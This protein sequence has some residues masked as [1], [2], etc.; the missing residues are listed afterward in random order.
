M[1]VLVPQSLQVNIPSISLSEVMSKA[2]WDHEDFSAPLS[3][4]MV[5][6][7]Q[8]VQ[9]YMV[10]AGDN[11]SPC[12]WNGRQLTIEWIDDNGVPLFT[13]EEAIYVIN[14]TYKFFESVGRTAHPILRAV[15]VFQIANL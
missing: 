7:P 2:L 12:R 13:K 4:E 5:I 8:T 1:I 10:V 9:L 11:Q 6:P 3:S 14:Y 15:P